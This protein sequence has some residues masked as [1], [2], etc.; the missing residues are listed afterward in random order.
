MVLARNCEKVP[1]PTM[2]IL[3]LREDE[4]EAGTE[5][6]TEADMAWRAKP[7]EVA[8]EEFCFAGVS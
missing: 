5:A 1:K 2:P 4:T 7:M 8:K 6:G 3:R